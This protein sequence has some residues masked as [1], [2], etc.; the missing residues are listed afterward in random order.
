MWHVG[1]GERV[2]GPRHRRKHV[3]T[4]TALTRLNATIAGYDSVEGHSRW[5]YAEILFMANHGCTHVLNSL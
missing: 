5:Y 1:T 4:K 2:V 3:Y